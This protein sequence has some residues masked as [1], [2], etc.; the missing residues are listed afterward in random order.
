[1]MC[2]GSGKI[3]GVDVGGTFTDL[4]LLDPLSSEVRLSKVPSTIE[5]QAFGALSALEQVAEDLAEIDLIVHGTTTTTNAVLERKLSKTGLITTR[6]FR[7][8]LELGRRTRPSPYGMTGKFKPIISRELRLEVD[9]RIDAEGR[10][11]TPLNENEVADATRKL[12]E[13]ECESVVIHFLHAYANPTHELHAAKIV[14]EVWPNE[15]ITTGHSLLSESREFERGVTAAVNASVQPLLEVY[16]RQL[17]EELHANGYSGE[18]L[19]MNGN[20]GMVS[21]HYVAREAAKTVMSGPAS[22][23]KA[24]AYTGSRA[25]FRNLLT[26]DMGGTSSDV[27][28]ILDAEPAVSN[29]IEIE[30]AMPIHVPMVDVRTVGAGGGSIAKI[31]P[32]GLLE[33]GP[34]SA[35]AV[36]GPICY[37]NGGTKPTISDANL[38]LGRLN[39]EKFASLQSSSS[40]E[41][42]EEIFEHELGAPLGI[43]AVGAA[44][45][46]VR[47]ANTKMAGAI[48]MVS[49]SLGADPR[50][51]A[52]FAFGGAG[53]LHATALARELAV[54]KVLIPAR[55][56]ITNALGCIVADLRH[57]FVNTV[58]RP[59]DAIDID[60]VHAVFE[61]QT[62]EGEN[63]INGE[64]IAIKEINRFYSVDMQF[65]GQTHLLRVDLDFPTP[66]TNELRAAFEDAYFK[67]FKVD[68]QEIR[69]NLVNINTSVVG[70]RSELDL[71]TLIDPKGKK[72]WLS[73]AE[74]GYR[75]VFFNSEW[76]RTPVYW[77]DHLPSNLQLKG[78]AI[79]E[80]MDSTTVLEPGDYAE[81]DDDG[82]IIIT[83]GTSL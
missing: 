29:E 18:V 10:V 12:L 48:R 5:N 52:L 75:R 66:S 57:D 50:D 58:N 82:N 44:E 49:I 80:Q 55:P 16:I 53:P 23:V 6:G 26:Y 71:S 68:L 3:V 56:G 17:V 40:I 13:A 41:M 35:G 34:E 81:C 70:R 76:H 7:D 62:R 33:V 65:V 24:A 79:I 36:P 42:V 46:V 45:A 2:R 59:L 83:I 11:V 43:N 61:R 60:D 19:V 51:F 8:V 73:E 64:K 54:P 63:L 32:G 1:M 31:N 9:E 20:G 38:L 15:F 67:R 4:I 27:A 28:L 39:P 72:L 37:G 47:I 77:R 25:G 22:G 21:S 74:T 14:Q 30:Y 78:P 69:V